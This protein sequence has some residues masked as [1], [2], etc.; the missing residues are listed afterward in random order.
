MLHHPAKVSVDKFPR[1]KI[2]SSLPA[3]SFRGDESLAVVALGQV[4]GPV[5]HVEAGEG[6]REDEARDHVDPLR[7]RRHLA[8]TERTARGGRESLE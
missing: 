3:G 2:S 5:H 6:Q 8:R 7:L 4:V 1:Q